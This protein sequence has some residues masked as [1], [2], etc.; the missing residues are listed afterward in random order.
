[1]TP[2]P[3]TTESCD[4]FCPDNAYLC[5]RCVRKVE[6]YL[7]DLPALLAELEITAT[8]RARISERAGPRSKKAEVYWRGSGSL[9]DGTDD[10]ATSLEA[11]TRSPFNWKA[12]DDLYAARNTLTS[13]VRIMEEESGRQ[14][15][16][17]GPVP[18]G[19]CCWKCKHKSCWTIRAHDHLDE[20]AMCLWL[21]RQ[22]EWFRQRR[23]ATEFYD[24]IH[25]LYRFVL[26]VI[27]RPDPLLFAGACDY[28][29][30]P[31]PDGEALKVNLYARLG[32]EK[33]ACR[34]CGVEYD[35]ALRRGDMLADAEGMLFNAASIALAVAMF[36]ADLKVERIRKWASRGSIVAHGVD[37]QGR[38]TYRLGDILDKLAG[39]AVRRAEKESVA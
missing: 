15:T 21:I 16:V 28:C 1:M 34:E 18:L 20:A 32:A 12:S 7:G 19:P 2:P 11:F 23:D 8:R 36:G 31:G 24:E 39:D 37:H 13:W 6:R 29:T 3:C 26:R 38:P 17:L 9:G 30:H 27:D 25:H 4:G 22:L 35:V 10:L 14:C 33:V 5:G